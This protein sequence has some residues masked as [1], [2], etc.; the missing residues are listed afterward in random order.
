MLCVFCKSSRIFK[1]SKKEARQYL[2]QPVENWTG[3]SDRWMFDFIQFPVP[4]FS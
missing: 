1:V 3:L 4:Q 2:D